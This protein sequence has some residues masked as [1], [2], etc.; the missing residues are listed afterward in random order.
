MVV[1]HAGASY[2]DIAHHAIQLCCKSCSFAGFAGLSSQVCHCSFAPFV[3]FARFSLLGRICHC[4]F[5]AREFCKAVAHFSSSAI[6]V[7]ALPFVQRSG[8]RAKLQV[9]YLWPIVAVCE[10]TLRLTVHRCNE[11]SAPCQ[12]PPPALAYAPFPPASLAVNPQP[13]PR[14]LAHHPPHPHLPTLVPISLRKISPC[15]P[16]PPCAPCRWKSLDCT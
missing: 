1:V 16:S 7:A 9:T 2:L 15:S 8:S 3:T 10:I 6:Q 13:H 11:S 12:R 4:F 14:P 5:I